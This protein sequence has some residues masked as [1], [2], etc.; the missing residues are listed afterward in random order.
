MSSGL[1]AKFSRT[2]SIKATIE[3]INALRLILG[4]NGVLTLLRDAGLYKKMTRP[5][6]SQHKV[7][8][9]YDEFAALNRSIQRIYG[10]QG[11]VIIAHQASR[12]SFVPAFKA[13]E[14][15]ARLQHPAFQKL[16]LDKK[17]LY[18]LQIFGKVL[19]KFSDQDIS[20]SEDPRSYVLEIKN[21]VACWG[22]EATVPICYYQTGLIRGALEWITG[23]EDFPIHE[24]NCAARDETTC[25]F[26]I[27]KQPY[28]DEERGAGKTSFLTRLDL[29]T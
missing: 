17:V 2:Y 23:G 1:L 24:E 5:F 20:L 7:I 12:K 15:I 10:P 14:E 3:Y 21:C 28:T 4:D 25:R 29:V 19:E 13:I 8:I 11:L 9:S 6:S 27:R 22:Q 18:G 16:P 26:R